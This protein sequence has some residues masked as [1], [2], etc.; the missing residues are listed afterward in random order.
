MGIENQEAL[1]LFQLEMYLQQMAD[2]LEDNLDM[3]LYKGVDKQ[4]AQGIANACKGGLGII[5][6]C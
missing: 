5:Q 2:K 6:G 1:A 3:K 4:E